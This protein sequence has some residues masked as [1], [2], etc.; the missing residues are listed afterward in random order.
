MTTPAAAN[1]NA[2]D[3]GNIETAASTV[4][5]T[6]AASSLPVSAGE[7][8]DSNDDS[9]KISPDSNAKPAVDV[10]PRAPFAATKAAAQ[11]KVSTA[12][13]AGVIGSSQSVPKTSGLPPAEDAFWEAAR[14]DDLDTV[15]EFIE[16]KGMRP[17]Q[18]DAGG[19]AAMHWATRARSMRVLKYL[20]QEKAANINVRSANYNATPLFW[21]ISQGRLDVISYLVDNGANLALRDSSENT[22]LHAAVH[23]GA[24][25]VVIFVACVQLAALGGSVDTGDVGGVTPLMWAT[26]QNKPEVVELLIRMG[27]NINAQDNNGKTPLHYGLMISCARIVDTLLAKGADPTLKDFG[28]TDAFGALVGSDGSGGLSPQDAATTYGF[29]AELNKQIKDAETMRAIEDPGY[30]LLGRSVRKSIGAAAAPTLGIGFSLMATSLYPWFVGVPL[31]VLILA[32]M[33]YVVVKFIARSRSAQHLQGLPYMSA[34]FQASALYIFLT[35]VT[36]VLPV[37]TRG[38][39]DGHSIPS[40]KVL[41]AAML[42]IFG[43]CMYF[44]YKTLFADPGYIGRN[45]DLRSAE[46]VIRKLAGSNTLDFNHFCRTCLNVRPL[47]SKHCRVCNRCVARFD[48]HCPWTGNCVGLHNHRHFILFL[49]CLCPG[50]CLYIVLVSYYMD[51]VFVLYDPIPGQPC[52]LSDYACGL[53]QSDSWTMASTIWIG[54]NCIWAT[55][56]TVAQLVQVMQGNTTNE[57]QTGYLRTAP[58]LGRKGKHGGHGHGHIHGRGGFARRAA[59]GL[60]R[61][62]LGM[63]GSV[64]SGDPTMTTSTTAQPEGDAE[65]AM[66][67]DSV[68]GP[69]SRSSTGS[70]GEVL[71]QNQR[72]SQRSFAMRNIGYTSLGNDALAGAR[73]GNPYSFGAMDNCLGFWTGEAEGKL[74]GA[75]WLS[76]MELSELAPYCPPSAPQL[77]ALGSSEHVSLNMPA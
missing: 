17:D 3:V 55:F 29:T 47:R 4:D 49:V 54:L 25:P 57:A 42:W 14:N 56:L 74:V 35:W 13:A 30:I 52:Y 16:T 28:I 19:N 70:S 62:V 58:H 31:G 43:C 26:Y 39:I 24:I 59:T 12:D 33:H 8:A 20:V 63:G 60:R 64:A 53:F 23:A 6:I 7:P 5:S 11:S 66:A 48:H 73:G 41:N 21:A 32:S 44:F 22:A 71:P 77:E 27:A 61:L 36:R 69:I 9:S 76:V 50:I 1:L 37:T 68:P 2:A 40:H 65:A 72:D 15:R 45:E 51:S 18:A 34:I 38:A 67:S 10:Q 75:N 46:S